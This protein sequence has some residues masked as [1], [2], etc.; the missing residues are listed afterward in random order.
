MSPWDR[1]FSVVYRSGMSFTELALSPN[2]HS[3]KQNYLAIVAAQ[4]E[5]NITKTIQDSQ[6][7]TVLVV[8]LHT[9]Y[10]HCGL[11][12]GPHVI[13][14]SINS[15]ADLIALRKN[16]CS[17]FFQSGHAVWLIHHSVLVHVWTFPSQ[18]LPFPRIRSKQYACKNESKSEQH[19][20][21]FISWIHCNSRSVLGEGWKKESKA[22]SE[23]MMRAVPQLQ[24]VLASPT[25]GYIWK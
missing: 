15:P 13:V 17:D 1:R 24:D 19:A 6:E 4:S 2:I 22:R 16:V 14:S 8:V 21:R 12:I 3:S 25:T 9:E 11:Y 20:K 23:G 7:G 18:H 10:G 5:P